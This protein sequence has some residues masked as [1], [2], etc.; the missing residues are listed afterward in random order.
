MLPYHSLE[1]AAVNRRVVGS[2]PTGRAT[3]K[4]FL[5]TSAKEVL[6]LFV[7]QQRVARFLANLFDILL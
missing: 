6:F 5:F 7:Q 2:S 4:P 3:E 1:H